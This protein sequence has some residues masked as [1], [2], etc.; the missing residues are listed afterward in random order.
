MIGFLL[1]ISI[2]LHFIT[3][4]ILILVIKKMGHSLDYDQL[5]K[6]KKEIE[7]LLA[8]YTLEL[9]EENE[10]FLNQLFGK[11]ATEKKEIDHPHEKEIE[12]VPKLND[13]SEPS[14]EAKALQLHE[15]GYQMNDIAKKLNK[16]LGE[17]ELLLKFNRER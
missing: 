15:Q 17:I 13:T 1:V 2:V 7:D 6:Q 4:L 3:F 14:F 8:S 11:K 16:G 12:S 9:K 5:T 10:H